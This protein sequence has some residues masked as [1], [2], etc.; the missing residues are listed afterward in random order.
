RPMGAAASYDVAAHLARVGALH[1]A[2]STSM[3]GCM[4]YCGEEEKRA[5]EAVL[6]SNYFFRYGW[7]PEFRNETAKL[8]SELSDFI[9]TKQSL[10]VTSGT[11]A[12]ICALV[13]LKVGP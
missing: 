2:P 12:L 10:A 6:E 4:Y 3:V 5:I 8:E 7:Q 13:G 9:G 11:A 1:L